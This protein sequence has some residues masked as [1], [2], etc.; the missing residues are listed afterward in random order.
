MLTDQPAG[1]D[2]Y[3]G[4]AHHYEAN[5]RAPLW[6][7]VSVELG[8]NHPSI[9]SPDGLPERANVDLRDE[10]T[11]DQGV[12]YEPRLVRRVP[13]PTAGCGPRAVFETPQDLN[14]GFA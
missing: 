10:A 6:R 3:T 2:L 7:P 1:D 11:S 12:Q 5:E 9:Q 8:C 13:V 4:N 14:L